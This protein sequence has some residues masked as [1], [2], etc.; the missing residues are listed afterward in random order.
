LTKADSFYIFGATFLFNNREKM[1]KTANST[2]NN[3]YLISS[4]S[5]VVGRFP[6][7]LPLNIII[8]RG[9]IILSLIVLIIG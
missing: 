2:D 4:N 5:N 1:K 3:R 8:L 6:L 9:L 7:Y